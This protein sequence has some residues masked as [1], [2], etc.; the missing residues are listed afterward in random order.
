M[1]PGAFRVG[2]FKPSQ[3]YE[4]NWIISPRRGENKKSLK[5]QPSFEL[6]VLVF[7]GG[8][9]R[10]QNIHHRERLIRDM[11]SV[12]Q[13]ILQGMITYPTFEKGKSSSKCLWEG[14]C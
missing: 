4:S 14:I 13:Y 1:R 3:K 7:Q 8:S 6:K 10:K 9:Q 12:S 2:G 5:P 11:L